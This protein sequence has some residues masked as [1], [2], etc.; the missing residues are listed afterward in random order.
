MAVWIYTRQAWPRSGCN[1]RD[2]DCNFNV[3]LTQ[4]DIT[5]L[6]CCVSDSPFGDLQHARHACGAEACMRAMVTHGIPALM[7]KQT[8]HSASCEAKR[9]AHA[10]ALRRHA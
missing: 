8:R 9:N 5:C 4:Q 6:L 2:M 1:I 10:E 3:L 7:C